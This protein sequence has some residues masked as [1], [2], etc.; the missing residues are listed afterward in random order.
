MNIFIIDGDQDL[1]K[2][3]LLFIDHCHLLIGKHWCHEDSYTLSYKIAHFAFSECKN[4]V[5]MQDL[6][7]TNAVIIYTIVL[8][9]N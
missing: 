3:V 6:S 9:Q 4:D 8:I 1:S 7:R 5:N 2:S